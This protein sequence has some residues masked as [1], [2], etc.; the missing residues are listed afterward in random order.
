MSLLKMSTQGFLK[1]FL[2]EVW[3]KISSLVVSGELFRSAEGDL[4]EVIRFRES[5]FQVFGYETLL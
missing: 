4:E 1:G 5:C 3:N 2:V